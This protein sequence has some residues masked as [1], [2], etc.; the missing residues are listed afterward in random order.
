MQF[1]EFL[2][3]RIKVIILKTFLNVMWILW[4]KK[5]FQ[6]TPIMLA[7]ALI[8]NSK[9]FECIMYIDVKFELNPINRRC[10][11]LEIYL[12]PYFYNWTENCVVSIFLKPSIEFRTEDKEYIRIFVYE[13][14]NMSLCME[15]KSGE[16][17]QFRKEACIQ[18]LGVITFFSP[19][20]M[21]IF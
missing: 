11:K 20:K 3:E 14:T 15:V 2:L 8:F 9:F 12:V 19:K 1:G 4:N 13:T 17:N 21:L 16:K 18:S 6:K 5:L 7:L 10:L